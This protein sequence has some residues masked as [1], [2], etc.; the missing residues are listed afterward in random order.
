MDIFFSLEKL[1]RYFIVEHHMSRAQAELLVVGSSVGLLLA[2]IGLAT[3][4][5]PKYLSFIIKSLQRNFTRTMLTG[6]ATG[7]LVFAVT[8][9]FSIILFL[10]IAMSEKANDQKAIVTERWQIPSQMPF[11]YASSLA[12]GAAEKESD[13]RPE[14]S[15]TWSFYGGT[16]D[17]V[18][19][20]RD[21][22]VFFFG[23]DTSKLRERVD[24]HGKRLVRMME[25]LDELDENVVKELEAKRNGCLIG[26]DR[27]KA[28]DKK[29]GE[30]ITVTSFNYKDIDLEFEIVGTLPDGRYNQNAFMNREYLLEAL[31]A[32]KY[33][34]NGTKHPMAD[35]CLN[36]VWLRVPDSKTFRE[37]ANQVTT[38]SSYSAPAVKCE[39]ASSGISSFLDAYRDFIRGMK[40]FMMPALLAI[41]ALIIS[42]AISIS[43][44]ERRLEMA[45]LKV[46]GYTPRH[47]LGMV[48]G[49]ALLIGCVSGLASAALTYGVIHW[50]MKGIKFPVGFFGVFDIYADCLW[51]GILFGGSTA[52]L[53][54]VWP[55][56][57][58]R[59]VKVSEVFA[60]VA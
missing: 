33:S 16:T 59:S 53:G 9:I 54:S 13:P 49:E 50:W 51:W 12:N 4:F 52:L 15:M 40:Y 29:V 22:F 20:S 27:L 47:I 58:A 36:L 10:D 14:D 48:L 37:V 41:M 45:V 34:H 21:K 35:R 5:F 32:Y 19:R 7:V 25:D 8:L 56:W 31:E 23:M 28:L 39:T 6:L 38:S 11:A 30:R 55:A 44:R 2:V 60:K 1:I 24:S 57:S 42:V 18:G 26:M 46:L 17:P 43:V 3:F